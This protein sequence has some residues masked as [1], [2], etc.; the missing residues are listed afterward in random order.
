M[1]EETNKE[2]ATKRCCSNEA[3]TNGYHQANAA[4]VL[5]ASAR[6]WLKPARRSR[7]NEPVSEETGNDQQEGDDA[8]ANGI[9][10]HGSNDSP[11][12]RNGHG[13]RAHEAEDADQ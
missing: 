2:C 9:G 3:A 10:H 12:R 13:H 5:E 4:K 8:A 7:P 6:M 1:I 11:R